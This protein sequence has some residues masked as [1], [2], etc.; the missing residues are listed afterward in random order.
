M[1]VDE[2]WQIIW[3]LRREPQQKL[4]RDEMRELVERLKKQRKDEA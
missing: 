4:S 2:W 3:D 1:T